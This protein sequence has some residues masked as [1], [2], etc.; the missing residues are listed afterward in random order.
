MEPRKHFENEWERSPQFNMVIDFRWAVAE[1]IIAHCALIT[2]DTNGEDSAGRQ[3]LRL[4][5]AKEVAERAMDIADEMVNL[6]DARGWFK[7]PEVTAEERVQYFGL[8]D[9]LK[10]YGGFS[11]QK[12]KE[13]SDLLDKIAMLTGKE[14][15]TT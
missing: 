14:K 15:I 4:L 3:A 7:T 6:G 13:L 5:T 8:L 11:E 10:L 12:A 1:R 9:K 2:A